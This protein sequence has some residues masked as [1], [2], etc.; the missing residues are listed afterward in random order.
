[1]KTDNL[2]LSNIVRPGIM[3]QAI[4]PTKDNIFGI[5]TT[6]F[7]GYVK[8]QDQD[9]PNVVFYEVVITHRG[10]SGKARLEFEEISTPIFFPKYKNLETVFPEIDRKHFIFI[11]TNINLMP[12]NILEFDNHQFL[13]W[14]SSWG[15]FLSKLNTTV[16][17]IKVWPDD[18]EHVLNIIRELPHRFMEDPTYVLKNYTSQE[19]RTTVVT[20]VR[21]LESVLS[22]C[23]IEYLYKTTCIEQKAIIDLRKNVK[24]LKLDEEQLK[25]VNTLITNEMFKLE[26]I[27]KLQG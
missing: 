19:F 23:A 27:M 1:M 26:K 3:F 9:F 12:K 18:S 17:R 6:G 7:I 25:K 14:A 10:K 13:G 8:G 4:K 24:N 21:H 16:K 20:E 5:G 11:N 15:C 2:F 22:R